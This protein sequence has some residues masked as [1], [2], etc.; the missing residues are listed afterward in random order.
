MAAVTFPPVDTADEYGIVAV[1]GKLDANLLYHA[2]ERGIFPWP[3]PEIEPVCWFAPQKRAVLFLSEFHLS[4]SAK[5]LLARVPFEIR[6]NTNFE[7]VIYE[8]SLLRPKQEG[9]WITAEM[10]DAYVELHKAGHA[11]SVETYLEGMLVGGLYG[12]SIGKMFCGESMFYRTS[13]ASKAALVH[14]INILSK[15]GAKWLDCQV[16]NPNFRQLGAREISRSRFMKLLGE[17][18]LE[19]VDMFGCK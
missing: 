13:G 3:I 7:A 1:G 17:A 8:C 6:V 5:R 18:L 15:N 2:Y 12:V 9:S 14:L 19:P 4:R 16:L 11:H 10:Q